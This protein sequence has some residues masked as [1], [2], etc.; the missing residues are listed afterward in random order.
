M[1]TPASLSKMIPFSENPVLPVFRIPPCVMQAEPGLIDC[2]C[3]ATQAASIHIPLKEART[4][5]LISST[6]IPAPQGEA[7]TRLILDS[8]ECVGSKALSVNYMYVMPFSVQQGRVFFTCQ[9]FSRAVDDSKK[10]LC[11]VRDNIVV[12]D[13]DL[14]AKIS[15]S[16]ERNKSIFYT[17]MHACLGNESAPLARITKSIVNIVIDYLASEENLSDPAMLEPEDLVQAKKI[18]LKIRNSSTEPAFCV[19]SFTKFAQDLHRRWSWSE[20]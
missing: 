14:K 8:S 20:S 3:K 7:L 10:L 9:M 18:A 13:A 19:F 5:Q 1:S 4:M 17:Q 6:M 2:S 16:F 12:D 15:Q 11:I